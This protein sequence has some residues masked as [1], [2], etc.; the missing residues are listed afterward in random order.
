MKSD[1][2]ITLHRLV[3]NCRTIQSKYDLLTL[4]EFLFPED[5]GSTAVDF[6]FVD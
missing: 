4:A 5:L 2:F 3:K 1:E 6:S